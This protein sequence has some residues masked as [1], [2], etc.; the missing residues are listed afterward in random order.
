M[1]KTGNVE[2]KYNYFK[3]DDNTL[4][5][6]FEA[7][8]NSKIDVTHKIIGDSTIITIKGTKKQDNTPK[9]LK[10]NFVNLRKFGDFELA[11]PLKVEEF[12]INAKTPKEGYPKFVNGV[13]II[14]YELAT[15]AETV[16]AEAKEEI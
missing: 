9:D 7:P 1:F 4:E 16:S 6:R 12:K 10:E 15:N 11:I 14:Q 13:F 5:I 8:G 3:P 2:I